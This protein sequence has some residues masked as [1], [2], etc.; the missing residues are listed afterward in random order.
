MH[1]KELL[2]LIDSAIDR[3]LDERPL[4]CTNSECLSDCGISKHEHRAHHE[5]VTE[6]KK[7]RDD[8]LEKM[9]FIHKLMKGKEATTRILGETMLKLIVTA[10]ISGMAAGLM[11]YLAITFSGKGESSGG[12]SVRPGITNGV[13][14]SAP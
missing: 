1:L 10:V 4:R 11:S 3:K 6:I 13:K 7:N 14:G 9:K 8:L 2:D 12:T 5:L